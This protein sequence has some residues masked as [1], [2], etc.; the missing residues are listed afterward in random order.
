MCVWLQRGK[1]GG[2]VNELIIRIDVASAVGYPQTISTTLSLPGQ[3][4]IL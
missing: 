2:Q 4:Y 3:L 1:G